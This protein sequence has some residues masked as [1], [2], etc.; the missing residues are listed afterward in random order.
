MRH[1]AV[2]ATFALSIML[3]GPSAVAAEPA[4]QPVPQDKDRIPEV[5]VIGQRLDKHSRIVMTM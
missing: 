2:M 5:H 3:F 4:A 1:A